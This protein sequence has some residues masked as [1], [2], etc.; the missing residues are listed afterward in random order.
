MNKIIKCFILAI[1][2]GV[3]FF[4]LSPGVLVTLPQTKKDCEITQQI[5]K[6][7]CATSYEAAGTH[8]GIFTLI[9]FCISL[10]F[11]K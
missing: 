8:A 4:L 1:I 6:L 11:I 9:I 10:L 2:S 3:L 7:S 5:K